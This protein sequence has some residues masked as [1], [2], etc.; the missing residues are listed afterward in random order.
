MDEKN[1]NTSS[2]SCSRAQCC[3]RERCAHYRRQTVATKWRLEE[4]D[5]GRAEIF[6]A[7]R[8]RPAGYGAAA[9]KILLHFLLTHACE[10][11]VIT[12][13]ARTCAVVLN[14]FIHQGFPLRWLKPTR[15]SWANVHILTQRQNRNA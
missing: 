4:E 11:L 8:P 7:L 5:L 1:T 3:K 12:N 10:K 9:N 14:G 6:R 13:P 15:V 2:R